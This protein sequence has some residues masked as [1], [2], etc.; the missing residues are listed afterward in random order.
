M[1]CTYCD[2]GEMR[3]VRF[4]NRQEVFACRLCNKESHL[5]DCELCEHRSVQRL[6]DS[7]EGLSPWACYRCQLEKYSCPACPRGWVSAG[8]RPGLVDVYTC[9]KCNQHWSS[10]AEMAV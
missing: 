7:P 6:P 1:K 9:D 5:L 8:N 3:L 2:T 10:L 4:D